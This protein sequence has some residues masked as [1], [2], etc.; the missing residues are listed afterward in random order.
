GGR[1]L[2]GDTSYKFSLPKRSRWTGLMCVSE[3]V[4]SDE[5]A[6]PC[7]LAGVHLRQTSVGSL[8]DTSAGSLRGASVD[9][10][11]L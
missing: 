4:H 9:S 8:R 10:S 6:Q 3:L 11:V 5:R 1:T 7:C 2:A